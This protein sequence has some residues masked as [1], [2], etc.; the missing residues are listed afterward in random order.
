MTEEGEKRFNFSLYL[1]LNH[2]ADTN[3]WFIRELSI[4]G[5]D[6]FRWLEEV[7][8]CELIPPEFFICSIKY[9]PHLI[10][11][12]TSENDGNAS[13]AVAT[14]PQTLEFR[15]TPLM[16]AKWVIDNRNEN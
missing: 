15:L 10:Y 5:M 16:A 7:S 11:D 13:E 14:E 4:G 8:S 9:T 12:I 6:P 1:C 2:I 3:S